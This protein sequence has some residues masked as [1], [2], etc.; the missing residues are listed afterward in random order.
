M[1]VQLSKLSKSFLNNMKLK[2]LKLDFAQ[3][4]E[5]RRVDTCKLLRIISWWCCL[6]CTLLLCCREAVAIWLLNSCNAVVMLLLCCCYVI[7]CCKFQS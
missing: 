7:A 5:S 6:C 2:I 3:A 4:E 1:L